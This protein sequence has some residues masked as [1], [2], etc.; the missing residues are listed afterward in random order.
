[1]VI[2]YCTTA[3]I[4]PPSRPLSQMVMLRSARRFKNALVDPLCHSWYRTSGSVLVGPN[5]ERQKEN[6][7]KIFIGSGLARMEPF[8]EPLS[9]TIA[10]LSFYPKLQFNYPHPLGRR[11]KGAH[12]LRG[13][14]KHRSHAITG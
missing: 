5:S 14:G 9:L 8:G 12:S 1:M 3:P 7:S 13:L 10:P 2:N 11:L 4:K 6:M